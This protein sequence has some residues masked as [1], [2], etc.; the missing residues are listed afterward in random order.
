MY[1]YVHIHADRKIY[2]K[3]KHFVR[4]FIIIRASGTD[5]KEKKKDL[6]YGE[7]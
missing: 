6:N 2:N 7:L 1:I 3:T 4:K 5:F